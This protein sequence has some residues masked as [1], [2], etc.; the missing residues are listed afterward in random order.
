[1]I[2]VVRASSD[3]FEIRW[4]EQTYQDGTIVKTETFT[5]V[6]TIILSFRPTDE[7]MSKNPLGLYIR[8]LNWS[9][10]LGP[11]GVK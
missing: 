10:D 6:A 1:V 2:Y 3:S 8:A 7:S 5:S 9:A 11:Q 4:R